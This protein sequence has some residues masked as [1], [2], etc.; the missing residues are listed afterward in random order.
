MFE[1]RNDLFCNEYFK[2]KWIK[3]KT[4]FSPHKENISQVHRIKIGFNEKYLDGEIEK[5]V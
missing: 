1:S 4:L 3:L 5:C 2:Y